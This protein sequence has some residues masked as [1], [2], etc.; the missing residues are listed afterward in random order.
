MAPVT[1]GQAG[2]IPVPGDYTGIGY[3]EL[4]VYRPSTGQFIVLV[5]GPN[6]TTTTDTISIPGISTS[7]DLS[8]L[9]PVPGNYDPYEPVPMAPTGMLTSGS[10]VVN[11]NATTGLVIGEPISGTGIP[12][13]TT[14]QAIG[15]T[16]ITLSAAATIS[17]SEGLIAS[18]WIEN[19][20]AAVYDPKT[21]VYTI[22]G[23]SS[24]VVMSYAHRHGH[25]YGFGR[26]RAR[27]H[28][29]PRRLSR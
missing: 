10:A 25:L 3:D 27:R 15:S 26:V 11:V 5:P 2:D 18:G 17:G 29:G 12:A 6:G 13:G 19:V 23:P 21:G 28:S 4:A 20:E 1:F 8:S 22:L 16:T 14:I 9:V 24:A 7:P